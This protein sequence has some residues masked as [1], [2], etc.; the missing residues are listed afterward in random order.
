[1]WI[2]NMLALQSKR[3]ILPCVRNL[4]LKGFRMNDTSV[5]D[6]FNHHWLIS[7]VA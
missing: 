6:D 3:K 5:I 4:R 1:M 2:L 7:A